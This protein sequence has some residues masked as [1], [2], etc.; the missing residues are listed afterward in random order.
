MRSSNEQFKKAE[1][2]IMLNEI[3]Y[4]YKSEPNICSESYICTI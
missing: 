3:I 2:L 1:T 4:V